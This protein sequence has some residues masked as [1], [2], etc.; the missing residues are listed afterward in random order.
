VQLT[1]FS[2]TNYEILSTGNT[3]TPNVLTI[4]EL[5]R[6]SI[7]SLVQMDELTVV[8]IYSNPDDDSFTVTAE[9]ALG[10]TIKVRRDNGADINL[11]DDLF[12]VGTE[13][14]IV[15]PIARYDSEYQLMVIKLE[16]VTFT[17]VN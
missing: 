1:G 11:T 2:R 14:S 4:D 12:E 8:S 10:N 16:D 17:E 15:A 6:D 7:G 13:F 9:D 5:S 3:V